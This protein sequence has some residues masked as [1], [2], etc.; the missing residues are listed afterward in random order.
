MNLESE[1]MGKHSST[2]TDAKARGKGYEK[3]RWIAPL[4]ASC[5]G[6][7]LAAL[8]LMPMLQMNPRNVPVGVIS[9]DEGVELEGTNVNA[10]EALLNQLVGEETDDSEL[11]EGLSFFGEE[12]AGSEQDGEDESNVS[13]Y[14]TSDAVNWIIADSEEQLDDMLSSGAC[15]A[16]L[17]IPRDFSKYVVGNAGR[18]AMGSKLVENLP[19]MA[20]GASALSDGTTTLAEGAETLNSGT[21]AL[22]NGAST[23]QDGVKQLPSAV[24]SAQ[25]GAAALGDGL[26]KLGE[27][28]LSLEAGASTLKEG[29][30][31]TQ[32]ALDAALAA[33]TA[34]TPDVAKAAAYVQAA[35]Q[36]AA[37]L[38]EGAGKLEQATQSLA[39]GLD[40]SKNG[41]AALETGLLTLTSK[42]S[43][44]E[45]GVGALASGISRLQEGTGLLAAGASTLDAGAGA[46]A[47]GLNSAA[48][49][50][51]AFPQIDEGSTAA[52][53]LVINQGKNPMV[54]NSLG[55]AISSMGASSGIAFE[56]TYINPLP[57]GMSMGFTHMILMMLTYI[58]SY[59][60]AVVAAN[61]I[62][63]KRDSLKSI[64]ASMGIQIAYAVLCGLIIGFCA[65]AIIGW[66]TG[67]TI[68]FIN[69][70]LFVGLASF[71]FQMLV[72]GALDLF[73]TA[74]MV[75]PIGL[76]VIG[77]GTAYLPTEF[78][79]AFWQDWVYPWDP[80]RF[81]ADGYRGILYMGQSFWNPSSLPILVLALIG[82]VLMGIRVVILEMKK[83]DTKEEAHG[84]ERSN[85]R[86]SFSEELQA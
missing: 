80:L 28:A 52:I 50:L 39:D 85:T 67:A 48:L 59:A 7:I 17:T 14:V 44:L 40:A 57:S 16:T 6:L 31:S 54:S 47:E 41:A 24:G 22:A 68:P 45:E 30:S 58:S 27:G 61:L 74:G 3:A 63:F 23:L 29:A 62:K 26:E 8:L 34:P 51:D 77:M 81:M 76:L 73:G 83:K 35:A 82:L 36:G 75:V 53:K 12:E 65:S 72:L 15:Y 46:L 42:A 86:S 38:E 5:V 64:L 9:L 56:V 69:L 25:E 10:G 55:S 21:S 71:A 13:G 66:G 33:L 32:Q 70:A 49:A 84:L 1:T 37:A 19:S 11:P 18:T 79:P 4:V 60:T 2:R 20:E 43:A 78:L